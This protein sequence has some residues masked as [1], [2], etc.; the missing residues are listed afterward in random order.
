[1]KIRSGI[2]V[3]ICAVIILALSGCN[4]KASSPSESVKLQGA[5]A[6]FPAPLYSKWFKRTARPQE[7]GSGLSVGRQRQREKERNRQDR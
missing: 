3:V 6:S 7:R 4:S 2:T 1:M 5:G